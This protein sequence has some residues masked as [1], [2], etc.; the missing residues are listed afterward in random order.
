MPRLLPVC[1]VVFF[2]AASLRAGPLESAIMAAM[3]LSDQP[4]YSWVATVTDDARTYD[5]TG[6]TI[7][8][9]FTHVKM[10][11]VNAVR[12]R[13]GRSVTDTQIEMIFLGNVDC[14]IDTDKGW[15]KP[16]D[17]SPADDEVEEDV[18]VSIG[19]GGFPGA[20]SA[21]GGLLPGSVTL[22]SRQRPSPP[23]ERRYSN[24]QLAI[25]H[26]HEE[27][28]VIVSSHHEFKVEGDIVTG[29]LTDLGA[30]LLLVHDGQKEIAP[31]AAA[32]TFK[33]WLRNG[34]VAK[35]QVKLEGVLDVTTPKGRRQIA[36]HQTVE[37][38]LKDIGATTLEIPE[39]ARKQ[40]GR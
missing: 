28:G 23:E 30:Q 25:C 6:R 4:N 26:P 3:R 22:P 11:V 15:K 20:G 39:S 24:L 21:N 16:A 29:T 40:L 12:R 13:L 32:G 14:V 37:T 36:V 18:S 9:G 7:R 17:L 31:V 27:L 34:M 8:G 33:L 35:Y 5:V 19:G 10:P 38:T 2:A 1:L